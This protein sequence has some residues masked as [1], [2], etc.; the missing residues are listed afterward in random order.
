MITYDCWYILTMSIASVRSVSFLH[1]RLRIPQS[2]SL[3]TVP[4][5]FCRSIKAAYFR[6]FFPCPGWI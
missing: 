6:L 2:F 1:L 4:Y 3:L 5:A